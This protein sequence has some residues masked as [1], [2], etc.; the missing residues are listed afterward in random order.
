MEKI[1]YTDNEYVEFNEKA[2]TIKLMDG[3]TKRISKEEFNSYL[4]TAQGDEVEAI[5]IYLDDTGVTVNEAQEALVAAT[6]DIKIVGSAEKKEK[7]ARKPRE[8]KIDPTKHAIIEAIAQCYD[9][10]KVIVEDDQKIVKFIV[11]GE[12]YKVNLTKTNKALQ[13]RKGK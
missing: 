9:A 4:R 1:Y 2:L 7:K 12:E 5:L 3:K 13:E 8:R 11:D 10:D 6:A